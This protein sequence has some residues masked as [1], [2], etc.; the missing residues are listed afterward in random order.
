[1]IRI[2]ED[3]VVN[4]IAAGE[5]VERPASVVKELVENSLDA[6]A[7]AIRVD[8]R[9]GGADLI[10]VRDDGVG[11]N[12]GDAAMSLERHATSKIRET[13]DLVGVTSLG[14]RGEAIPSIAA[15]SRF[16]IITRPRT[17]EAGT[18]VRVEGGRLEKIE[19]AG[20]PV[21]TRVTV[22][23]LFFNL[24]ARR[25][26]LKTTQTELGHCTE[27]VL[28]QLL[29]HPDVDVEVNH[30]GRRLIRAAVHESMNARAAALLGATGR[31]L[32]PLE[33]ETEGVRITGLVSPIGVHR[34]TAR[35]GSYLYV[36]GR[37]VQD[38]LLRRSIS[39]AYRGL[40]PR[41]RYPVVV[42][43]FEVPGEDVDVNVHPAK[44]EVRFRQAR[45]LAHGLTSQIR[46]G[47]GGG[48]S[49]SVSVQVLKPATAAAQG[50]LGLR[51]SDRYPDRP[52][53]QSAA[54]EGA[55]PTDRAEPVRSLPLPHAPRM[56]S[57]APDEAHI[58]AMAYLGALDEGTL[59]CR[60][61]GSLWVIDRRRLEWLRAR[62]ILSKGRPEDS[63]PLLLPAVIEVPPA[64]HARL[65]SMASALA[66]CGVVLEDFGRSSV[67]FKR[68]PS[69][70][71]PDQLSDM[72]GALLGP[73]SRPKRGQ[74]LDILDDLAAFAARA[75]LGPVSRFETGERLRQV[76]DQD[77]SSFE[78]IG[79]KIEAEEISM[80]LR[81]FRQED[82]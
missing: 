77:P 22:R 20:A 70:L 48:E 54:G 14:F 55:R 41:G 78:R 13:D 8:L 3:R 30:E 73:R 37:Y 27:T 51:G 11:M 42:L 7:K 9:G 36:N 81:P 28:R 49:A 32:V 46:S 5:V 53:P 26:F 6:G 17:M 39:E 23:D 71:N 34:G 60:A 76:Y 24:P 50:S 64:D 1:V 21:G 66:R 52:Q 57:R 25:K 47:L 72:V 82:A 68:L 62:S 40:V 65:L 59:V 19:A 44:T 63:L 16:E 38:S 43:R 74:A 18:R 35:G 58:E 79:Y 31:Q 10:R 69:M 67:V 45:K 75:T 12:P 15:V 80:R 4:Q 29:N 56:R 61:E 33:C 2:L